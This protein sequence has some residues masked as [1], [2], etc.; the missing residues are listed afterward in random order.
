MW[1]LRG[2]KKPTDTARLGLAPQVRDTAISAF[3]DSLVRGSANSALIVSVIGDIAEHSFY[4]CQVDD[5][6]S[7]LTGPIAWDEDLFSKVGPF[8]SKRFG[9]NFSSGKFDALLAIFADYYCCRLPLLMRRQWYADI[10]P[11]IGFSGYDL[12]E[13]LVQFGSKVSASFP[14]AWANL[15]GNGP[16]D[17]WSIFYRAAASKLLSRQYSFDSLEVQQYLSIHDDVV[18]KPLTALSG[19]AVDSNVS[20]FIRLH[21]E[22]RR[23]TWWNECVADYKGTFKSWYFAGAFSG[24]PYE[25]SPAFWPALQQRVDACKWLRSFERSS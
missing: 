7:C 17:K 1:R 24:S 19:V 15:E 10:P 14:R 20:A 13:I 4:E 3:A 6:L 18:E 11:Q 12:E 25:P 23:E 2:R 22:Q 16:N 8:T 21:L 5:L 9:L